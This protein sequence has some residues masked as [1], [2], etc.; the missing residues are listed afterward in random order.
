MQSYPVWRGPAGNGISEDQQEQ[1]DAAIAAAEDLAVALPQVDQAREDAQAAAGQ[2]AGDRAQTGADRAATEAARTAAE[3]YATAAAQSAQF[4]DTIAAGRAAVADGEQFGVRA[5][6]VDGLTRPTIYRRDS[7]TAQTLIVKIVASAEVDALTQRTSQIDE[8]VSLTATLVP[9]MHVPSASDPT[10]GVV[11]VAYDAT[12]GELVVDRLRALNLDAPSLDSAPPVVLSANTL[13]E[14][15]AL[16]D[17]NP[18]GTIGQVMSGYD[19]GTYELVDGE[20]VKQTSL[21]IAQSAEATGLEIIEDDADGD[22]LLSDWVVTKHAPS[23]EDPTRAVVLEMVNRVT[24]EVR[25]ADAA[26]GADGDYLPWLP[27]PE[28]A[29]PPSTLVN[30][31]TGATIPV[32]S[33]DSEGRR[34]FNRMWDQDAI[35][36]LM[37]I[38]QSLN[39]GQFSLLHLP[40]AS[41][42]PE[43]EAI[44]ARTWAPLTTA[45]ASGCSENCSI[46]AATASKR[47]WSGVSWPSWSSG[48]PG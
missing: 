48:G 46:A 2:A 36:V 42:T 1:V 15:A 13:A 18:D 4:Y 7:A 26:S 43:Y 40:Y 41:G 22:A 10:V 8:T 24:G 5:G 20:F 14:L 29:Y 47:I 31:E 34:R 33:N 45:R 21:T 17:G 25:R 19:V 23:A 30:P 27:T 38:G 32:S 28:G 35:Y 16:I 3:G 6:G 37:W 12:T 11:M 44:M 39:A 9:V